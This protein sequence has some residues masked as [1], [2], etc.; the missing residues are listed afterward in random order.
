MPVERNA[1]FGLLALFTRSAYL[2]F[3][4]PSSLPAQKETPVCFAIGGSILRQERQL[5]SGVSPSAEKNVDLGK[6]L[7]ERC[8]AWGMVQISV[9]QLLRW[10][11]LLCSSQPTRPP[12]LLP[13]RQSCLER[14]S[15]AGALW[16]VQ[17][18]LL[19]GSES[20]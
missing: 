3:R 13:L 15:Q 7:D 20:V 2:A 11:C 18:T 16:F 6:C 1:A 4:N 14:G 12:A 5:D 10:D 17:L 8:Q 9:F 19:S